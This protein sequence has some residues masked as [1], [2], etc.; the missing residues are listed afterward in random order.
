[1]T[2]DPYI[3]ESLFWLIEIAIIILAIAIGSLILRKISTHFRNRSSLPRVIHSPVQIAIWGTALGYIIT[4]ISNH[5]NA[6]AISAIIRPLRLTFIVVCISWLAVRWVKWCFLNIH[7]RSEKVGVS[8][9][10]VHALNKLFT[11][12]V[13][14]IALMIIFQ[15]FGVNI[16]PLLAFGG[17]GVAGLAFAAQ[18]VIANFFGGAM[19]HFTQPFYV[20]ELVAIPSQ[21]NFEGTIEEIGWYTTVIRDTEMRPVYFPNALFSKM[22]VINVTRRSHRRI[23]ET[24]SIR[25][26]DISNIEAIIQELRKKFAAHPEIDEKNNI[27]VVFNKFGEYGVEIYLNLLTHAVSFHDFLRVKQ[28]LLLLAYQVIKAH[29]AEIASPMQTI[30]LVNSP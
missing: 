10:T 2:T 29:R 24:I 5:F 14:I 9:G 27:S 28:D 19:L 17:I 13:I 30:H 8:I 26:E 12:L 3:P 4:I 23:I 15:I 25:L 6:M 18:D 21:N 11:F 1:M 22:N 7:K 20:G 16:I